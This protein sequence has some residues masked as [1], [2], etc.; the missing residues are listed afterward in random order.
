MESRNPRLIPPARRK[1]TAGIDLLRRWGYV[2]PAAIFLVWFFV[3][4]LADNASRSIFDS[5]G[6]FT[7]RHYAQ[8]T[9]DPYYLGVIGQ[10]L[11]LSVVVTLICLLIGYPVAYYLVRRAQRSAPLIIFLLIS[12]LL[13]SIVMRTYGWRVLLA[14][15]GLVN[16]LLLDLGV[17]ERPLDLLNGPG[18]ATLGLVH[19]LVPFM[20]LSIATVLQGID[21][22][23]EEAAEMLGATRRQVFWRIV[24]PLSLDGVGTGSII[25]FMIATGSFV[26]LLFLGGGSIQ[27]LPL[28]IYQQFATTRNFALAAG[29]SVLLLAIAVACLYLQL[30]II[31]RKGIA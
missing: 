19:V 21:R 5:A 27:T 23:L 14:R 30:R 3:V 4:P 12:P 17:I 11:L 10:T 9:T 31:K 28:L 15:R 7:L 2:V 6:A 29:M 18:S 26:T 16:T 8:L 13:T 25:V 22:R 20:V 1:G 24:F